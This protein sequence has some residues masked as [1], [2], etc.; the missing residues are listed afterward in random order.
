M[1]KHAKQ[2]VAAQSFIFRSNHHVMLLNPALTF[3]LTLSCRM[4][5][6]PRLGA[7]APIAQMHPDLVSSDSSRPSAETFFELHQMSLTCC[8]DSNPTD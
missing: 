6:I 4:G 2:T 5:L 3:E 8:K 1:T 7:K